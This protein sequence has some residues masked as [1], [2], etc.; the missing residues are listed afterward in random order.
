[1]QCPLYTSLS[2]QKASMTPALGPKTSTK[3]KK[4]QQ[5]WGNGFELQVQGILTQRPNFL[6]DN[7]FIDSVQ[8]LAQ[9]FLA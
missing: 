3:Y 4:R 8:D 1:M 5:Q 2:Q 6:F 9:L 7:Y